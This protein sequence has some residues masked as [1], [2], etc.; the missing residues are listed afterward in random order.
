VV[1]SNVAGSITSS[2]ATLTVVARPSITT[3]PTNLSVAVGQT[4]TFLVVATNDCG[5]G[6]AFQWWFQ[7]TNRLAAATNATFTRANAQLTDAGTYSVIVSNL[8]GSATSSVAT[9]TVIVPAQLVVAPAALDFGLILT[10]ATAK[11][12]FVVSNAGGAQLSGTAAISG[13]PFAFTDG[14]TG[15]LLVGP[16]SATNLNLA[17]SPQVA[18]NFSNAV[19]F[20]SNGGGATNTITGRAVETFAPTIL[21]PA[22]VGTNFTFSFQSLSGRTYTV[23]FKDDLQNASW[24]FLQTIPGDGSLKNVVAPVAGVPQRFYRLSVQ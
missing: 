6:L 9:L 16:F 22:L 15:Q 1:A 14:S 13:G 10:G 24:S 17:F 8:A 7:S 21:S 20:A 11:A 19:T 12:S 5:G 4:A 3:Q 23:Q 18:G 2:V